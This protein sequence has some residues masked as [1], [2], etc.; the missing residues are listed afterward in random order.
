MAITWD[1]TITPIDVPNKIVSI[2][3]TRTDDSPTDPEPPYTVTMQNAD[4]STGEK[5][6]E[7]LNALWAKYQKKVADQALIDSIADEI[8]TLEDNAKNNFEGR[9]T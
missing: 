8:A 5:K 9:E 3:A 6:T 4:I 2:S 1:F 7:A